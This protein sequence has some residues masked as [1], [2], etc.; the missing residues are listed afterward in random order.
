MTIETIKGIHD[1][2]DNIT[3][4]KNQIAFDEL[5]KILTEQYLILEETNK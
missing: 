5:N 2:L 1:V 3:L 4:G